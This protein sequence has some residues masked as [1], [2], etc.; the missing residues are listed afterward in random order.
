MTDEG[1]M[2]FCN[3]CGVYKPENSFYRRKASRKFGLDTRCKIHFNKTTKEDIEMRYLNLHS[4]QPRDWEESQAVLE[5]LG[6]VFCPDCPSVHQQFMEKHKNKWV[7][8]N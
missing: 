3:T 7:N 1:W 5:R 6:Y 4:L 2:Y 8:K